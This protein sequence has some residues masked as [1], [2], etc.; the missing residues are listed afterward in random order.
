MIRFK[1]TALYDALTWH[2]KCRSRHA[3][4]SVTIGNLI[5]DIKE[6]RDTA[7]QLEKEGKSLRNQLE[8]Q[9]IIYNTMDEKHMADKNRMAEEAQD[10]VNDLYNKL[11]VSMS[12]HFKDKAE[13]E[14][15]ESVVIALKAE[16][17][18]FKNNTP[19]KKTEPMPE[20]EYVIKLNEEGREVMSIKDEPFAVPNDCNPSVVN[21]GVAPAKIDV[22][23][24]NPVHNL[25]KK[26]RKGK[27]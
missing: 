19:S 3:A 13:K 9:K 6:I 5:R 14:Y 11:A 17:E 10:R 21:V 25:S 2:F 4:Q 7:N 15:I 8:E 18:C 27:K 26:K 24:A 12:E 20:R 16:Y 22:V 23:P 1:D